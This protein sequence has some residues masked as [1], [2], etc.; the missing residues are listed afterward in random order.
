MTNEQYTK[1]NEAM[2]II[3]NYIL[4]ANNIEELEETINMVVEQIKGITE[5]KIGAI[6]ENKEE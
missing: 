2:G 4:Q 1:L 6:K 3:M 5:I